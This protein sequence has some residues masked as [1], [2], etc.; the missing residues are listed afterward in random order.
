M[1]A[2]GPSYAPVGGR[3]EA[4][5]G[6]GED[7]A[8]EARAPGE[9][10]PVAPPAGRSSARG[11]HSVRQCSNPAGRGGDPGTMRARA[12]SVSRTVSR[13]TSEHLRQPRTLGRAQRWRDPR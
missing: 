6:F 7:S 12:R 8:D 9:R 13:E 3:R 10:Y 5:L 1:E 11:H 2:N 4:R